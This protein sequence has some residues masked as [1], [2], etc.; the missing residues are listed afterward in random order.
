VPEEELPEEPRGP[1][2]P[3]ILVRQIKI[4]RNV[5]LRKFGYSEGC[6]GCRAAQSGEE[7][8]GHSQECRD[9]IE[10]RIIAEDPVRAEALREIKRRRGEGEAA[11][12]QPLPSVPVEEADP[13]PAVGPSA[14]EA[15]AGPS[16]GVLPVRAADVPVPSED[17]GAVDARMVPVPLDSDD[18]VGAVY[19]YIGELGGNT[20]V[21][22]SSVLC[23]DPFTLRCHD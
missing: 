4:R 12:E 7:P 21:E 11:E 9:R 13:S 8:R 22:V 20:R 1:R 10:K 6:D 23:G 17:E 2:E 18:E 16:D 15:A 19:K 14:A 5:E 3:E